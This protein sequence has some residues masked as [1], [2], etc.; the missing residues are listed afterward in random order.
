MQRISMADEQWLAALIP[1]LAAE[2]LTSRFGRSGWDR[3]ADGS[4]ITEADTAMQR[5]V[6]GALAEHFPGVPV[7]AEEQSTAAQQ[8]LIEEA[9]SGVWC[10][11]P[12][13]GTTNFA[14]GMPLFAVSLAL[15]RQG[16]VELGLVHD[17]LRGETFS[18]RLGEGARLNGEPLPPP[19]RLAALAESVAIVDFKRLA[20]RLAAAL[21]VRPPFRSQR[22]IGSVALDWCWLAAGRC[23]LYLHGGQRLWDYAAGQLIAHEA[24]AAVCLADEVAGPCLFRLSLAQR[25]ALGA[26]DEAL[27]SRWRAWLVEAAAGG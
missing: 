2:H 21:A 4:L 23:Q 17:P 22:S 16:E 20:A 8:A 27:L 12:L 18:A 26:C 5:A 9:D 13:D 19:A 3:K 6:I 7:L 15:I 11:D 14:R 25:L 10:L 24:G 1:H